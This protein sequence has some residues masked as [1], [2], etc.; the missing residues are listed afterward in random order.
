MKR[1]V[2]F[3]TSIIILLVLTSGFGILCIAESNS[4]NARSAYV[5]EA[6]SNTVIQQQ[7][8][9]DKYPIASMVK[10]MTLLIAFENIEQGKMTINE[11]IVISESASSMG[12]SQMFLDTGDTY[13]I[14]D[15][16]KGIVVVSANDASVAI[17]ERIAGSE[18]EFVTLMNKRA[19]ELGMRNTNFANCTGLPAP[20]NYSTAEDV[21]KMTVELIKH[22]GYYKYST[23][24]ME[25][26]KHPDG[27]ITELVNTNKLTRFYKGCDG[28]KTGYTSEALFCL[29]ASA[30]RGNM[31][32]I[33]VILG[34]PNSKIRFA[35]SSKLLNN[36]FN[37][38]ENKV[39]ID[40]EDFGVKFVEIKSG[41]EDELPISL[42]K[43]VY[44][45][46]KKGDSVEYNT[47]IEIDKNIKAPISK[48][49]S[50]GTL[51]VMNKGVV[52]DERIIIANKDIE[53]ASYWDYIIKIIKQW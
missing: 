36:A 32:V 21:A 53:S 33:S 51:Y 29:S 48:G 37:K 45:L 19:K 10:I 47:K 2:L 52:I 27:R 50:I 9:Q 35:E 44:A 42:D 40:K 18:D 7:N 12:G 4:I 30:Q 22:E 20:S 5:I 13:I 14:D 38:Y 11:E 41:K 17:A 16:L 34:A 49:D 8:A 6:N 3:F 28:G 26:F 39:V 43:S 46:V 31:R 1:I 24:W 25:E 23:I 15:M